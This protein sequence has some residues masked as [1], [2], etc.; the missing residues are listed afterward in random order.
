[1]CILQHGGAFGSLRPGSLSNRHMLYRV[2]KKSMC[3][4]RKIPTKLL[5]W[6]WPSQNTFGMW[7]VLYWTRYSFKYNQQDATFYNILYCCQCST[8]FRRFLRPS[9]G[10]QICTHSICYTWLDNMFCE[11][12]TVCLPW[13]HWTKALLWFYDVAIS[14]FHSCVVVDL[15]Q[16]LSEWHLLLSAC[17]LVCRRENVGT[18]IRA[19]NEH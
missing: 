5:S 19:T 13:Q 7:S 9:S 4:W 11:L 12:A 14:A 3:T 2:I 8:C 17:V 6:R 18:W 15:W 1:M 10:A 16:S